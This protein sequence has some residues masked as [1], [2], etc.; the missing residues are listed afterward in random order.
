[1]SV[2]CLNQHESIA[3]VTVLLT[4]V[5]QILFYM[6]KWFECTK[7]LQQAGTIELLF[8]NTGKKS[9]T[10]EQWHSRISQA[11]LCDLEHRLLS[12]VS[13]A[14]WG[15]FIIS[16]EGWAE[17]CIHLAIMLEIHMLSGKGRWNYVCTRYMKQFLYTF[18]MERSHLLPK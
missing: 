18:A 17:C 11:M 14:V 8:V 1:M 15:M 3:D 13:L 9:R 4:L 6:I 7:C 16:S 10:I 5:I 2:Y 12:I